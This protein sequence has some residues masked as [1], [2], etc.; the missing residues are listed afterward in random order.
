MS[1]SLSFRKDGIFIFP[2]MVAILLFCS[3]ERLKWCWRAPATWPRA[4]WGLGLPLQA[5]H[6]KDEAKVP[7]VVERKPPRAMG[8]STVTGAGQNKVERPGQYVKDCQCLFLFLMMK[9]LLELLL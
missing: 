2:F 1:L 3:E 7:G 9:Q 5:V 4:V 6:G 8:R